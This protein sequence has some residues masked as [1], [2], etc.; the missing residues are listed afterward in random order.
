MYSIRPIYWNIKCAPARPGR[1]RVG[2]A[3]YIY[4]L[5]GHEEEDVKKG[6]ETFNIKG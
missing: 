5:L 6:G 1:N 3:L 2:P 4:S